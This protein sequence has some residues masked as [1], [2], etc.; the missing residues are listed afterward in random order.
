[1]RIAIVTKDKYLMRKIELELSHGFTLCD[2]ASA[3]VVIADMRAGV[4]RVGQRT[5]LLSPEKGEGDLTIPFAIGELRA[6]LD[7]GNEAESAPRLTLDET[8][9]AA[10]LDGRRIPLTAHEYSLLS[11]LIG[12]GGEYVT[13][14]TI[15]RSVWNGGNDRLVNIY[16]H[17]LRE[18]LEGD[19]ERII[20]SSRGEGYRIK[21]CYLWRKD[22]C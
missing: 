15:M 11:L 17:Y 18:K 8:G 13:R 14:E 2:A 5:V 3:D 6:L 4:P 9:R 1:M 16:V 19:G 12:G 22:K 21:E 7:Y 10:V 20:I